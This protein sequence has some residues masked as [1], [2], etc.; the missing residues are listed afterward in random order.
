MSERGAAVAGC[1]RLDPAGIIITVR[2]TPKAA[3]DSVDG[4][5]ALSAGR[6]VLLARVRAIPDKG[7]ANR[8]LRELLA[9]TLRVLR[10]DNQDERGASIWMRMG[11]G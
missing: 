11:R 9:K 3:R 10:G 5:G 4:I 1:Y 2:L 8:A 7:E 6:A